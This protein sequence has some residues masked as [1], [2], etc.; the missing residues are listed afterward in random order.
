MALSKKVGLKEASLFLNIPAK[1]I[2]RW[3]ISGPERKKGAGRKMRDPLME[4]NLLNWI[5]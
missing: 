3:E 2:R 1:N 4:L 5:K